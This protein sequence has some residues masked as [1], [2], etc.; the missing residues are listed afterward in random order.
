MVDFICK[1]YQLS[2]RRVER[3]LQNEILFPTVRFEPGS[4]AYEA[5][6]LPL[7]YED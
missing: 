1:G 4:S 7:S 5:K 2:G 6:A 3:E